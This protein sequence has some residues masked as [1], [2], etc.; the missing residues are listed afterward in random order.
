M[1]QAKL[2]ANIAAMADFA[3][4]H[5]LR[6]RPHAKTHKIAERRAATLRRQ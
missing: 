1:D 4:K 2:D 3:A 6:L 5:N